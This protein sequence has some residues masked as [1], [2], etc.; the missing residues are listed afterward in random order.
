MWYVFRVGGPIHSNYEKMYYSS[1]DKWHHPVTGPDGDEVAPD[2]ATG[3]ADIHVAQAAVLS[4]LV[5]SD[6]GTGYGIECEFAK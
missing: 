3:F 4:H 5:E 1:D 2:S 6:S